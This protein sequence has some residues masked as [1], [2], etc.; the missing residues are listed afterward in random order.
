MTF[1]SLMGQSTSFILAGYDS[2]ANAM[3]FAL[4]LISKN[5][6]VQHKLR[7]EIYQIY[8][9]EGELT[10]QNI[11]NAKYLDAVLAGKHCSLSSV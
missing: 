8:D 6:G 2:T 5:L 1:G 10:Y 9:D 7:K 3:G 11:M 4:Y